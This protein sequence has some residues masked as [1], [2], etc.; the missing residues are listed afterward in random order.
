MNDRH[1]YCELYKALQ[2]RIEHL[3]AKFS[4]KADKSFLEQEELRAPRELCA[5]ARILLQ[6]K[7]LSK[8]S[9]LQS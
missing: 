9:R 5:Q 3:R 2:R 1:I 7:K 8:E 6:H 4:S